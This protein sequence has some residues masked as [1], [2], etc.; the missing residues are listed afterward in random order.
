MAEVEVIKASEGTVSRRRYEGT[1]LKLERK[2]V[3]AYVRVSTD[4]E[5][6][7]NS[8]QSQMEYYNDKISKNKEW[9]LVGIY[10]DE[11]ITSN[12]RN[13]N[14]LERNVKNERSR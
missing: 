5:E 4:D 12:F 2:K 7:L 3:A 13:I 10:S 6:Q 14:K 8:F 1:G 9:A 11:A